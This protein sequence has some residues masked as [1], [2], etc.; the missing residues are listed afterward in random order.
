MIPLRLAEV[1]ELCPGRLEA[2]PWAEEVTD[3]VIDS[4]R[5]ERGAL[6]VAVGAG[7]EFAGDAF[8]R[9]AAAVLF[10]H[11]AF[12]ALAALGRAVRDRSGARVVGITGST[13]KTSTKDILL[14]LCAP[15]RRT[16]AN[17][18]SYNA[19]LGVP[20]TLCR[21]ERETELCIVELAMR[22]FGQIASLCEIARPDVGVIVNVGPAHLE[23]VGSLDGVRRAKAELLAALPPGA[24]AIVPVDFPVDRRDLD[25]TRFGEPE[26]SVVDGRTLV[27]FAGREIEFDFTARH[28]ARNA[29]AA[30]H[31]AR[32]V[33]VQADDRVEVRFSAWRGEEM[34]LP[35]GGLL[36]VDCWNANPLSMA[37]ALEHLRMRSEGRRTVA[38]LGEM[39]ELGDASAAYHRETGHLARA[40]GTGALVAVGERAR[41]YLEGGAGIP[42]V[43]WVPDAAAA[44]PAVEELVEPADCV[45]V[46]GSRAVGLERVVDSLLTVRV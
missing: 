7:G 38:V 23:H 9:G 12:A 24:P 1:E 45:L 32:A 5:V 31:A 33:G 34:P 21:L 4:R 2:S 16:I 17:E 11:D 25:V 46:K 6:F 19:E 40:L 10:P 20:L 3:V 27:R 8:A 41:G 13:G 35:G 26:V 14:A 15:H 29:L 28:Q 39:A 37:A 43:R 18:R 30:L 44:V 36:V 22:G 42:V